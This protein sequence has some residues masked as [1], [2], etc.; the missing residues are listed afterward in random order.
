MQFLIAEDSASCRHMLHKIVSDWGYQAVVA[1]DGS[2]A[3]A[4]LQQDEPPGVAIL[5][6]IMPGLDGLQLC[7]KIRETPRLATVYVVLL[8]AKDDRTD[9]VAGLDAGADDYVIKP[10]DHQELRAR[11]QVGL[12]VAALQQSLARRVRELEESREREQKLQKLLPICAWC[13]KIRDDQDYW[14]ELE[15][16][17]AACSQVRFSHGICPGCYERLMSRATP[18]AASPGG[19]AAD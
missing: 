13:K 8:T 9:V 17:F 12:R 2:E 10:F 15:S 14:Q 6:W 3:W 16:Y 18:A 7:R 5:D 4:C 1:A 11:L 19:A